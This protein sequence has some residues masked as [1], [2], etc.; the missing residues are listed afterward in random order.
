MSET[1]ETARDRL[2]RIVRGEFRVRRGHPLPYGAS[3]RREGV[4][5]SVFSKHATAVSLVLFAPGEREP[6]LELPLDSR[7]NKTGDVWHVFVEGLDPGVEYGFRAD[8][9]ANPA[10]EVMRFDR[11]KVLIDPF[12]KSVAGLERWGE[13]A[14][15]KGR[16]ERLRS[17]VV[18]EEFD[19]GHERPL[20]VPL[21]DSVIYEMHVRGFTRHPSAEVAHPG[22]F[23][24]VVEKIPYLKEL[25]VT[26]V[27]LMPVTEF[28]ECDNPRTN[29]LT[30]EPLRN[31]WGYQPVSFFAPKA[32][33][34]A[35]GSPAE[36][37]REF[38]AMVKALH[39]AG[40]EV[41]LDIVFNHTGEGD[42]RGATFCWRGLDNPTYYLLEPRTG[43]YLNY[44]GCGNTLNCNHPV[45]RN[46]I[47]AALRYW[48][49][50]MHVDGFRF[51][52][53]SILG[54]GR[55]GEVL[56]NPPLIEAIAADPVMADVKLIAEAWDAAGLY[57]VG[58]FPSWGRWAEWNGRFRDELRRFVKSDPGLTR[59]L[60]T[61][62]EGSPDLY[63]GS[64]RAPWHSINF[65]TSHDGFT[66]ADLV[67]YNGRHNWENGEGNTDGQPENF[68]W[69]C[70]E[71][72]PSSRFEVNALRRRQQRNLLSLLFLSQGVPMIQAGDEFGRTQRGNNNA[73]CQ[74]NETSWVDWSLLG[75]N[76]DLFR[77]TQRLVRFRKAHPSLRRRTFFEDEPRPLVAWHGARLGK[78]DWTGESRTLGMHLLAANGDE[79]I[80]VITNA[81]WEARAFDLPKPWPGSVWRRF[82][83]TSLPPGE[84]AV[85]PGAEAPV[86]PGRYPAGPRSVVVLVGR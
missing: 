27:E 17:R 82:V 55:D 18:D 36:A 14:T 16:L 38:K 85:E 9:D 57:Q 70:G 7:Y 6:V 24:G 15:P 75:R 47:L 29:L 40:L 5:F 72:G 31:Y 61:R 54:R 49:T 50:E 37:V 74:D 30:G 43:R 80:Y 51:D 73:Y 67:A 39:E 28:E 78:P 76:A 68:S 58:S 77:F 33:Y 69:N 11:D 26:A 1:V 19:W 66:L 86:A 64:D 25:G 21:A 2:F 32:S 46:Q 79:P 65:V 56:P 52:L 3:A 13:V 42:E 59:L 20:A 10:P 45:L 63:R 84:D 53:A 12:S 4:N 23:R 44:S 48:V 22:T 8:R 62:L 41:I 34:A 60:A 83:D 81:H 71:E 35:N